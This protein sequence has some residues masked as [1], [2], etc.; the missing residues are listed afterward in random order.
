M[1]TLKYTKYRSKMEDIEISRV[2]YV[3]HVCRDRVKVENFFTFRCMSLADNSDLIL[4]RR[5][6]CQT[7]ISI[8]QWHSAVPMNFAQLSDSKVQPSVDYYQVQRRPHETA[9][10]IVC[11]ITYICY[12]CIFH[13]K[14]I[15]S[16]FIDILYIQNRERCIVSISVNMTRPRPQSD[17]SHR[18]K[19][20]N[21]TGFGEG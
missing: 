15:I 7:F 5:S 19:G 9:Q 3:I 17:I 12:H 4:L 6:M 13:T 14:T 21:T 8:S 10:V 11:T 20:W 1:L 2:L 16:I 18:F